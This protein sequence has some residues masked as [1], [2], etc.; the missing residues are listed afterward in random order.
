LQSKSAA[1]ILSKMKVIYCFFETE[2]SFTSFIKMFDFTN[3]KFTESL[4]ARIDE[5][6]NLVLNSAAEKN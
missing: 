6:F 1:I 3:L 2:M 5:I 4:L